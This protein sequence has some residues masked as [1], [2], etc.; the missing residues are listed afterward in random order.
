MDAQIAMAEEGIARQL[1]MKCEKASYKV[2]ALLGEYSRAFRLLKK[3]ATLTKSEATSILLGAAYLDQAAVIPYAIELGAD[4]NGVS[5]R[6]PRK[7]TALML[8]ID[9]QNLSLV[10]SLV[11]AGASSTA[12]DAEGNAVLHYA[13]KSGSVSAVRAIAKT[14]PMAVVNATGETPLFEAVKRNQKVMAQTVLDLVSQDERVA[15]VNTAD[16]SG[17]TAFALAAK[18]GSRDVLDALAKAGATYSEKDLILAEE[19]DHLAV[20]QWLVAEGADV[21]AE[22]VMA[23]ACPKTATGR[24][25]IHEG[26]V[27]EHACVACQPSEA[28][29][30]PAAEPSKKA[31]ASGTITFTVTDVK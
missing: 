30:A 5:E 22:G 31:E 15:F 7:R 8:A 18:I 4:V 23:K 24:Y 16:K 11:E 27:G 13:V 3:N 20:A 21:N 2:N 26:G 1:G 28:V 19:G 12:T 25:L 17:L 6:D 10:K 9:A 14:A 29:A